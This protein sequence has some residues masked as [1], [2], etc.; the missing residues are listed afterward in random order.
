MTQ[1]A[2]S[3]LPRSRRLNSTSS[4]LPRSTLTLFQGAEIARSGEEEYAVELTKP[5]R[6]VAKSEKC[7]C[8]TQFKGMPVTPPP[9]PPGHN[10]RLSSQST[11]HPPRRRDRGRECQNLPEGYF[12]I[13]L[14]FRPIQ[15]IPVE[16]GEPPRRACFYPPGCVLSNTAVVVVAASLCTQ[17]GLSRSAPKPAPKPEPDAKRRHGPARLFPACDR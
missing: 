11:P 4:S 16:S 5:R 14:G 7:N 17:N 1:L 10:Q 6:S 2:P 12:L 3:Q 13:G 9:Q 8:L 15:S